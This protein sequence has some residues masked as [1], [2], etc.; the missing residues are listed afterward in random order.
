MFAQLD[1]LAENWTSD[2]KIVLFNAI[3]PT[4][5]PRWRVARTGPYGC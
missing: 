2:M 1:L 3:D 4:L 5:L